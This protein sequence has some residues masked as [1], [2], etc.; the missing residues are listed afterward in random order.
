MKQL[1]EKQENSRLIAS[2]IKGVKAEFLKT[3]KQIKNAK[4]PFAV[5]NINPLIKAVCK[6]FGANEQNIRLI[7]GWGDIKPGANA[8]K[9]LLNKD[10]I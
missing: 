5:V 10:E 9:M 2:T 6:K 8:S 3:E 4:I 1:S 7:A